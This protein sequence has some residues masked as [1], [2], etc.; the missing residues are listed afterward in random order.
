MAYVNLASTTKLH[1]ATQIITDIGSA[2]LMLLYTGAPPAGPD[3][4]ATGT[5]LVTLPLAS[6]AAVASYAVQTTS[7]AAAGTGGTNGT[8]A[9]TFTGGGGSGATGYF[10]VATG[11][12]NL[13]IIT[14]PGSG[15]TSAPTISGFTTA[16]LVG[17]SVLPVMTGLLTFNAIT[18]ASAVAS[19]AA[20]WA[21][22]TK[23]DG[24]TGIIDLDVGTTNAASVVMSNTVIVA[25]GAVSCSAEILIE[26]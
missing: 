4:T 13:V 20:G 12:I 2:G 10:T 15:Y 17:A 23:A 21:R 24:V 16:G 3:I 22:V 25:S 5:L 1:R 6:V 9:L 26:A 11:S 14:A 8:Y 19:G 7:V 18:T